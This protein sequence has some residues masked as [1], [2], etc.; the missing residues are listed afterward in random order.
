M[1]DSFDKMIGEEDSRMESG[2]SGSQGR[3]DSIKSIVEA[4]DQLVKIVQLL[5]KTIQVLA[6]SRDNVSNFLTKYNKL[7]Y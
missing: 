4:N 7:T 3:Y 5:T 2:S 6:Q 1:N